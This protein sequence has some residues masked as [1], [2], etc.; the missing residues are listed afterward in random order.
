M[1][2]GH[3]WNEVK[4]EN[5]RNACR[6]A[7]HGTARHGKRSIIPRSAALRKRHARADS[8]KVARRADRASVTRAP[9]IACARIVGAIRSPGERSP[10]ARDF[11]R[12]YRGAL[13]T[14]AF[15]AVCPPN[16]KKHRTLQNR[17]TRFGTHIRRMQKT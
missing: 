16:G 13:D 11:E 9:R 8:A 15:G 3:G 17:H 14:V 2:D 6:T 1:V 4:E 12:P 7:R 5:A 10:I